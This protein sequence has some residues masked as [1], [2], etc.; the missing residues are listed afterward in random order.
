MVRYRMLPVNKN[1]D[2]NVYLQLVCMCAV[3]VHHLMHLKYEPVPR[4]YCMTYDPGSWM[5]IIQ[6]VVTLYTLHYI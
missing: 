1:D 4:R 6:Y 3:C 5:F 2:Y